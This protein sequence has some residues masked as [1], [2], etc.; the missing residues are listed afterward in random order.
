MTTPGGWNPTAGASILFPAGS[1]SGGNSGLAGHAA[2]TEQ[3]WKDLLEEQMRPH[4][5]TL[6]EPI[7]AMQEWVQAL[8]S[9]FQ[10]DLGPLESLVGQAIQ[11]FQADL[12]GLGE[13][14]EGTYSGDDTVLIGIQAAVSGIRSIAGGLID[15]SRIPQIFLSQLSNQPS[16]NLLSGFGEFDSAATIDGAGQWVWDDTT[17]HESPGSARAVADG[18]LKVLTSE[19]IAVSAGQTLDVSGRVRWIDA[20]ASSDQ[21]PVAQLTIMPYTGA[22]TGT[23]TVI[24]SINGPLYTDSGGD[25]VALAGI[26][27]VPDEVDGV[28]VRITCE[29]AM[30][31]GATVWWDDISLRKTATSLPQQWV[32]GLSDTLGDLWDGITNL[33]DQVLSALGVTPE[34]GI[35]DRILD[36]S[37][38]LGDLLGSAED[39]AAEVSNLITGLLA[40]PASLLGSLPQSKI[41]DLVPTLNAKAAQSAVDAVQNFIEELV[42]AIL[43]AIRGIPVVGGT[44]AD[45]ISD[46]GQLNSTANGT[47]EAI[48][49]GWEGNS[50]GDTAVNDTL[51]AIRGAVLSD[52]TVETITSSR[53]WTKPEGITELMVICCGA[54][55]N[56]GSGGENTYGAGGRGGGWLAQTFAPSEVPNSVYA[57]IGTPGILTKFGDLLVVS[58][59]DNNG[60][61]SILGFSPSTSKP[62]AGG[63][64]GHGSTE[65]E[66]GESTPLARIGTRGEFTSQNGT[67]GGDGGSAPLDA[68]TKCGG[69][70]GGGGGGGTTNVII[71]GAGGNGGNGGYPGGGGGGGGMPTKYAG[72]LGTPGTGGAGAN[73]CV[74]VIYK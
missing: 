59:P 13:A 15:P 40:S 33:V 34:G 23:P 19:A 14:I 49:A 67:N 37:D 20:T 66:H 1:A 25:F 63:A 65:A 74:W 16:P 53:T 50:G 57:S 2:M 28:R 47:K 8:V 39:T 71:P 9:V 32:S 60:I 42:N 64:G 73:G 10:G 45:V 31:P 52:Y 5:E 44:L 29:A 4:W 62:G 17:G 24:S 38:E 7:A 43:Q 70:G 11:G 12:A 22:T 46:L 54:G 3:D 48:V 27:E 6:G 51:Q 69:A 55:R 61:G 72:V 36:L 56:G 58:N 18:T 68:L 26:Y 21:S 35:L 30:T 41:I